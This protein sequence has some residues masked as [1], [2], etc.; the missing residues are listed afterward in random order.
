M[1]NILHH[2]QSP[3]IRNNMQM[4]QAVRA[5]AQNF[6][7]KNQFDEFN[8]PTLLN[9]NGEPYN[10]VFDIK[11][12]DY[13]ACLDDS[14]QIFKMFLNM[15]GYDKYYQFAHCFRPIERENETH[16]RL[17]EFTQL[18]IE[19]SVN[20]LA[21]LTAFAVKL[22]LEMCSSVNIKTDIQKMDGLFCRNNYGNEMKPNLQKDSA[23]ASV[24]I[25][26]HMPLSNG[27]RTSENGLIPCHHIFALPSDELNDDNEN[28]LINSTT[29]SFDII[30]N[31]IEVGGGDLRIKNSDLQRKM[32]NIFNVK[33]D[34]YKSYL[35]ALDE[36]KTT[37]N[38]GFAIGIERLIMALS[39]CSDIRLTVPFPDFY[40]N[41]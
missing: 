9:Q 17:C 32:M 6:L 19:M 33:Q 30:I 8:T 23:S 2:L 12:G 36:C 11:I 34:K 3:I 20:T 27:E 39:G 4:T 24:V 40:K 26:E 7:Q 29:E 1:N 38:G 21:E 22:I 37:Q 10:S 14:P 25:I 5:A 13:S 18:D 28:T 15:A 31:G 41:K 35:E 16:T